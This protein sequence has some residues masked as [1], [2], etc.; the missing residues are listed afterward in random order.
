MLLTAN[1]HLKI[2]AG[3]PFLPQQAEKTVYPLSPS[4]TCMKDVFKFFFSSV[5]SSSDK[6][7]PILLAFLF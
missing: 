1:F 2:K 3:A 5:T 7:A 4:L 6:T